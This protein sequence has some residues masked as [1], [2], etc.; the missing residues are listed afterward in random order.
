MSA[1]LAIIV[2]IVAMLAIVGLMEMFM[3]W[4]TSRVAARAIQRAGHP[5]QYRSKPGARLEPE[6]RFIVRLSDSE[7]V[8]D[9]PDGKVER[10]AWNDLQKV[11]VV[12]TDEGPFVADVFWVLHGSDGGCAI[13]SSATGEKEFLERLQALPG[14]NNGAVIE[15]MACCDNRRF[16]CWQR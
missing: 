12:T 8:C 14:F 3:D 13:P 2:T 1:A 7:V 4:R 10:V 16:L 11:E 9:R 5:E 15:A 6:S